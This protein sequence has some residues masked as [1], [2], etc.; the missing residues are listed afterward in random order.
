MKNIQHSFLTR[1][2]KQRL[3]ERGISEE[4]ALFIMRYGETFDALC[5]R[6]VY[7]FNSKSSEVCNL[8]WSIKKNA[9][10]L[11]VIQAADGEIITAMPCYAKQ[12][13]W[14]SPEKTYNRCA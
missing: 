10:N 5:G 8:P 4:T 11:A 13:H 12:P 1:H 2:A 3:A 14:I 6:L 9:F 7:W